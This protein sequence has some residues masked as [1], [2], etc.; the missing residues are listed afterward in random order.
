MAYW[1]AH[2][3]LSKEDSKRR[4][5]ILKQFI[6]IADVSKDILPPNIGI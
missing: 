4:A 5:G 3:V 6:T 2:T 1:V